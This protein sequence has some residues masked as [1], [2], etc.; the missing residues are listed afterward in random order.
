MTSEWKLGHHFMLLCFILDLLVIYDFLLSLCKLRIKHVHC[1][2]FFVRQKLLSPKKGA[3]AIIWIFQEK[4][5]HA[6]CIVFKWSNIIFHFYVTINQRLNWHKMNVI[7]L[8][9]NSIWTT[10]Y[11]KGRLDKMTTML[12]KNINHLWPL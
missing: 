3:S 9:I 4:V 12:N 5:E 2:S 10:N 1:F 8:S 11:C 7:L 6:H